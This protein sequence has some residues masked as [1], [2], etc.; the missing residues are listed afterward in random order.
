MLFSVGMRTYDDKSRTRINHKL[1][2]TNKDYKI[3]F[4][5]KHK[6]VVVDKD[7]QVL[8]FFSTSEA[9]GQKTELNGERVRTLVKVQQK[10]EEITCQG[11]ALACGLKSL[12]AEC[13][14]S[15]KVLMKMEY[16][17]EYFMI[18][19]RQGASEGVL[20]SNRQ[21]VVEKK[22]LKDLSACRI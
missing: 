11:S 6:G 10:E 18:H 9:S 19:F 15:K 13:E 14:G 3:E 17:S 7:D 4:K 1:F 2:I 21:Q 16:F 12:K 8:K 22:E 5:I 20:K